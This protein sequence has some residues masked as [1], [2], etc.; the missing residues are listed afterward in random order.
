MHRGRQRPRAGLAFGFEPVSAV[1]E[2]DTLKGIG[3]IRH[4]AGLRGDSDR[5][6]PRGGTEHL[7]G[8]VDPSLKTTPTFKQQMCGI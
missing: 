5:T 6:A 2:L 8:Q 4:A 3:A 7:G 1:S